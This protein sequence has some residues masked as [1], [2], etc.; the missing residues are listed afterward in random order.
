MRGRIGGA[1]IVLAALSLPA[2]AQVVH[3]WNGVAANNRMGSSIDS[4]PDLDLDGV[5]DVIIG[6]PFTAGGSGFQSGSVRICSGA[7]GAV[8]FTVAGL[9]S[10]DH[11]GWSVAGLE[12]LDGDGRGEFAIGSPENDQ[13]APQAGLVRVHSGADASVLHQWLGTFAGE[14]FGNCVERAGDVDGDGSV[15]VLAGAWRSG[16]QA[17]RVEVRSGASGALIHRHAGRQPSDRLGWSLAGLGDVDG[18]GRDDYALGASQEGTGPGYVRVISGASGAVLRVHTGQ[19]LNEHFGEA[20]AGLGDVN[21]DGRADYAAGAIFAEVGRTA[22]GRVDVFSGLDGALLWSQL[23]LGD[24]ERFGG[25]LD[26]GMDVDGDGVPDLLVG[27]QFG[28]GW[29]GRA[30]LLSGSDGALL[31]QWTGSALSDRFGWSVA[32]SGDLD[33][34]GGPDVLVG[35]PREDLAAADAGVARALSGAAG[36]EACAAFTYCTA[37]V[38]SLGC[39][40]LMDWSGSPALSGS[41]NFTVRAGQVLNGSVGVFLTSLQSSTQA[42]LGGMLCVAPPVTRSAPLSTG[43]N[44]PPRDC[45]GRLELSF[46]PAYM[47]AQGWTVG[48]TLHV[49][50][51]SR[52]PAHDDGSAASLSNGLSFVICP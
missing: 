4:V 5:P 16:E 31:R 24:L 8:L 32:L 39:E 15:D 9:A 17:G 48:T 36:A 1:V 41:G 21:G 6:I 52:D 49:Q 22:R 10:G 25:A 38:N 51:W 28:G 42:A 40:P 30:V 20:L 23:G 3:Q 18:D 7:S 47:A 35:A 50:A 2:H 46:T 26:G 13:G 27:A 45:S 33:A 14:T 29:R 11:S 44:P 12:D 19:A 43:G 34:D 37:K